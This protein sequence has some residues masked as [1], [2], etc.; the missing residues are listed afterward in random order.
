MVEGLNIYITYMGGPTL[1]VVV[2]GRAF[3]PAGEVLHRGKISGHVV[4]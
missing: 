4:G 2:K 1:W 3:F